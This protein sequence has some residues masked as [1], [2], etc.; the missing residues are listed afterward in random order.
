L[1]SATSLETLAQQVAPFPPC[2]PRSAATAAQL[3]VSSCPPPTESP[4]HFTAIHNM[5]PYRQKENKNKKITK[6]NY[7]KKRKLSVSNIKN[8]EHFFYL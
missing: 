5:Q 3:L 2:P 6:I 4:L 7:Q 1:L 8:H